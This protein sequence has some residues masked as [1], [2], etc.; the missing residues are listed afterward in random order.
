MSAEANTMIT[1]QNPQNTSAPS[2]GNSLLG[3]APTPF[4]GDRDKAK[5]FMHSY[6]RWWRLND[7]K[8]AFSIPYKQVALCISYIR[9]KKVEDWADKQQEAMDRKIAHGYTHK[10]KKLWEE[11]AKAFM[12]TYTDIAE[13][14]KVDREL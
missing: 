14:V 1:T 2:N 3:S 7:E 9:G 11:F 6:K 5:E 12:D 10:D 4:D 13:G 8:P